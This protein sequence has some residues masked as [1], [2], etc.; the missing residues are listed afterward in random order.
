MRRGLDRVSGNE[1]DCRARG[2]GWQAAVGYRER[3]TAGNSRGTAGFL[4][5][6][7]KIDHDVEHGREFALSNV[8]DRDRAELVRV[9]RIEKC[10]KADMSRILLCCPSLATRRVI[11]DSLVQAGAV[12]KQGR[13][14]KGAMERALEDWLA[15]LLGA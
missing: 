1:Y 4:G 13:P 7:Q 5:G 8:V 15:E 3:S 10:Y 14:P 2:P 9:A 11:I 12:W 6:L